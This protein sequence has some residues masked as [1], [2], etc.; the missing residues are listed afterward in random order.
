M[1]LFN[2]TLCD[3]VSTWL[4]RFWFELGSWFQFDDCLYRVLQQWGT[5][6]GVAVSLCRDVW[7]SGLKCLHVFL[8]IIPVICQFD[9]LCVEQLSLLFDVEEMIQVVFRWMGMQQPICSNREWFGSK[10]IDERWLHELLL[11][12]KLSVARWQL[13]IF[14]DCWHHRLQVSVIRCNLGSR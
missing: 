1:W 2:A 14:I 6:P 10:S 11:V 13:R 12:F 4:I 3:N 9:L 7:R 8:E 5:W